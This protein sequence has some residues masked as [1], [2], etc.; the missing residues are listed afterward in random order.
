[1]KTFK[2][3]RES[4]PSNTVVTAFSRF[5]PISSRHD[6]LIQFV[7]KLAA[8]YNAEPIVFVDSQGLVDIN[9]RLEYL[10]ILYPQCQFISSHDYAL[11]AASLS[12]QYRNLV[13]IA[14]DN[15]SSAKQIPAKFDFVKVVFV[16]PA[17]D[18]EQHEDSMKSAA[19]AGQFKSF[20]GKVPSH[21]RM[22]DAH[23]MMNDIRLAR[24]INSLPLDN[25]IAAP[26]DEMREQYIQGNLYPVGSQV[27]YQGNLLEIVHRGTNYLV[28]KDKNQTT[29]KKFLHEL[30]P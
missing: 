18:F 16:T 28:L 6:L 19:G 8:L 30:I 10:H 17:V 29:I 21:M 3:L 11:S 15:L 20:Q 9:S 23:R 25:L 27:N 24:G 22:I 1:M 13:V 26:V 14:N 7:L 4:L 12:R 2:Q 5:D